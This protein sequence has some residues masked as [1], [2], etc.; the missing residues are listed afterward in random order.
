MLKLNCLGAEQRIYYMSQYQPSVQAGKMERV[1]MVSD[2][3]VTL[4]SGS[5]ANLPY[6]IDVCK[7]VT[8]WC[9]ANPEMRTKGG[10]WEELFGQEIIMKSHYNKFLTTNP[11]C[12]ECPSMNK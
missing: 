1:L 12:H 11:V 9:P 8:W 4:T 2:P 5:I 7:T 6:M 10:N 3:N